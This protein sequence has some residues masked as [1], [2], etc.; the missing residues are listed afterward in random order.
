MQTANAYLRA[1]KPSLP[2]PESSNTAHDKDI[3]PSEYLSMHVPAAALQLMD[4]GRCSFQSQN[5]AKSR[6][7]R[8]HY[9]AI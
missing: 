3:A 6:C 1:A 7:I 5:S 9:E 8:L 4:N 2:S